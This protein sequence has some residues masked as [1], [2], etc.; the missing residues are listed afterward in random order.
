MIKTD[1]KTPKNSEMYLIKDNLT[2]VQYLY[3]CVGYSGNL[4]KLE[5]GK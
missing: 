1:N 5:D 4:I 3:V 2:N